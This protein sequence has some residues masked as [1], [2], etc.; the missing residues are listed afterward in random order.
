M[1]MLSVCF[2]AALVSVRI[3]HG[4]AAYLHRLFKSVAVL[5]FFSV[6]LQPF[7]QETKSLL[8]GLAA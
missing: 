4:E 5:K 3:L 6:G 2:T 8:K 7:H 1:L